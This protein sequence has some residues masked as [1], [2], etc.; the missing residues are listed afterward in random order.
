MPYQPSFDRL[1]GQTGVVVE[2][3]QADRHGTGIVKVMGE[4]WSA[5]T[6]WPDPLQPGISVLVV[7]RVGLRLAVLPEGG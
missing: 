1:L 3:I 7:G 5:E 4:F 2:T 6:D